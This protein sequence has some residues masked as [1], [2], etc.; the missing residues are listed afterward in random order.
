MKRSFLFGTLALL[1]VNLLGSSAW[2]QALVQEFYVALPET[3]I[4]QHFLQLASGTG[5]TFESVVSITVGNNGTRVVYDH[6]EDGY[7]VDLN[8]PVQSTTQIWGDGNNA[9]GI[10]PGYVNDPVGL[11]AGAVIALRNLVNLPRNASQVLYDGRDRLGASN[12][13]V[14]SRASWATNPGSV[15]ADAVELLSTVDWGTSYVAPVGEDVIFPTPLASS[16]FEKVAMFVQAAENGT[17]VQID[18]NADGVTDTTVTLNRG[19]VHFTLDGVLKGATVTASKPVQV[20]MMVGDINANYE[21]R[22]F[23]LIP[24]AK[25]GIEYYSPVGTASD[26]NQAYAFVYNPHATA[27]EISYRTRVGTGTFSIP[28]KGTYQFLLPQDSATSFLSTSDREFFGVVTAG[29]KPS[30]NQVHDWGFSLAPK[31]NLTTAVVVGWGPGSSDLT[32]NGSPVWVTAMEATRIYV[33][34]NGDRNGPLTDPTGQKYDVYR[35]IAPMEV[36]KLYDPDKDQTA[37][38][39]YT[40]DGALIAAAWGQDPA[41]AGAGNPFLDVGTTVPAFPAPVMIK[42]SRIFTDNGTPGLSVGDVLEYTVRLENKSLVAI[43]AVSLVD[44]LP[45]GL[46]YVPNTTKVGLVPVPDSGVTPFPMDEGGLLVPLIRSKEFTEVT[47]N[48]TVN[49]T[50]TK[51]NVA[52]AVG[53]PGAKASNTINVTGGSGSTVC[54]ILFTGNTGTP[55]VFNPGE[56]IYVTINDADTS[57]PSINVAVINSTNGDT[58]IITLTSISPGVYRNLSPL[59]TS[60]SAGTGFNDGT[61]YVRPGDALTTQH[62]DPQFGDACNANTTIVQPSETKQLYL[63]ADA[64]DNDLTGS[65]DRIDPVATGDTTTNST[66]LLEPGTAAVTAQSTT[67]AVGAT[68]ATSISA[69]HVV[70]AGTNR[71][72]MVGVSFEDDNTSGMTISSVT[73]GTNTLTRA[74]QRSSS[75]EAKG[76]I[77]YMLNPPVGSATVTVTASGVASSDSMAFGATSFVG[78][79][80][81][82][83]FG[84]FAGNTGTGTNASVSVGSAVGDLVYAMLALDDARTATTSQNSLWNVFTETANSDGV[85]SAGSTASGAA[86]NVNMSWTVGSD[87][88]AAMGV[89]IKPASIP[90]TATFAQTPNFVTP[91]S[92][93]AGGAV[94]GTAWVEVPGGYLTNNPTIPATLS[95]NGTN[96]LTLSNPVA[97]LVSGGV[98]TITRGTTSTA[99]ANSTN[100]LTLTHNVANGTNRLLMVSVALGATTTSGNPPSIS[101]VTF[102]GTAMTLVGSRVSGSG[103][104]SDDTISYIYRTIAPQTG[105][106]NVVV[107]LSGNGSVGVTATTF[108]NVDQTTPLGTFVSNAAGSGSTAAVTVSSST[109]E[110]V[111]GTISADEAPTLTAGTG[112]TALWSGSSFGSFTSGGTGVMNGAASVNFSYTKNVTDQDW[113]I[114]AVPIRPN[115]SAAIYRLDWSGALASSQTVPAGQA[116]TLSLLNNVTDTPFRVLYDSETRP[117]R[118]NLPALTVIDTVALDVYDAPYPGGALMPTLISGQTGYVRV[119]VTDPFGTYDITSVDLNIDGPGDAGDISTALDAS[120]VVS[121]NGTVKIYELPWVTTLNTGNYIVSAVSNEG[122]EGTVKSAR[123]TNVSVTQLDLGTP[124]TT[125]FNKEVYDPNE[126]VCVTT[127]DLDENKDPNTAETVTVTVTSGAG[128]SEEIVL[129]E[130]GPDTGIF[131][132]CIPASGTTP[133]DDDDGTLYAPPGT[134]LTV[135]YVD[136][137]DPSDTSGDTASVPSPAASVNVTKT[138]LTPTDG[139]AMVGESVSFRLRVSN[140]GPTTLA[141]VSVTDTFP[142]AN[143]GYQSASITPTAVNSGSLSWS[144]V[145]P[146]APGQT[147]DIIVYFTA[148]AS[149]NPA[150]NSVTVNATGGL[151]SNSSATVVITNPS[152]SVT[153]TLTTPPAGPVGIGDEVVFTIQVQNTGDTAI[154]ELPLEDSFS[155]ALF[156]FVSAT[157]AP[158]GVGSGSLFWAD[159]TG[160]GALAPGQST[161]VSVRLRV[162]GEADPAFNYAEV[163]YATDQYGDPVPPDQ[164]SASIETAAASIRG[165]VYEDLDGNNGFSGPDGRLGGVTVRLYSDP[166]GDGDPADGILVSLTTT[167]S[168]GSYSFLNLPLGNY[169]VVQEDLL[170]YVSVNDTAGSP[171]DNRIPVAVAALTDYTGHDFLDRLLSTSTYGSISGQVRLDADSDGDMSDP[172]SGI[173]GVEIHLYTDPNGDGNPSDGVLLLTTTT[174]GS[175]NY[176]FP[177]VPPGN[178]VVVELDPSGHVSTADSVNPNDN[179]IPVT[180]PESGTVTGNDFLDAAAGGPLATIGDRVWL[181]VN[182]NGLRDGGEPGAEGVV[183]WLYKSTQTPGVDV[184][185]RVTTTMSGGSYEF[186]NLPVGSYTIMLPA[187]NFGPGGALASAPLSSAITNANDDNVDDDDN[188]IQAGAPGTVVVSPLFALGNAEVD[189]TKDF[190]FVPNSS[191]GSISGFVLEDTDNNG[192]GDAPLPGVTVTLKDSSG[193]DIDSDPNTPGV[194][195]TTTVTGPDGGYS[196]ANLPPGSYRIVETHPA[197]YTSVS[198]V[199]GGDLDIIGD[200]TP[201]VVAPGQALTNQTFVEIHFGA[202]SGTVLADTTGNGQGDAPLANVTLTLKDSNGNDIDS[203]PNTPGVQPTTTTTAG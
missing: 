25:W 194:Q 119:A 4:R 136:P 123:T 36:V 161:S 116:I 28:A 192:S 155:G 81:S 199:D 169:V 56:P 164:S 24:R 13:I 131:S 53:Y 133:G 130:T 182:N 44:T 148:L 109:S 46:T 16:M 48:V 102:R 202:I 78:V 54:E 42:T 201:V 174:N 51:T 110:V 186:A 111:F 147:V 170:G 72:L 90:N 95:R 106:G 156:Q 140:T 183:V 21:S 121:D 166:N 71:L 34:Y 128:D 15:L 43:T 92:M 100:S 165:V 22:W 177:L 178:Y 126:T 65:L 120:R 104:S 184:P 2:A 30:A 149:A 27:L 19:E 187:V 180:L 129:T 64:A 172:D 167:A 159:L 39:I 188:G 63:T 171:T 105:N 18:K 38:R 40:L 145:G 181:D 132:A 107:S 118:I 162:V 75:Q 190:G 12:A 87:S 58:E 150:T 203:D 88:W 195:P 84:T 163:L 91:F 185:Y 59:P 37:M 200:V 41:V 114:A 69:T 45:A 115:Q 61:L 153:K 79:N 158:D 197:G 17:Q 137:D 122:F 151:T 127:T 35:D 146:L 76:E 55:K 108:Y 26:G 134:P 73:Y 191:L 86:G 98:D 179:R 117:S 101:G 74:I 5:T 138:R 157:P 50:G 103:G 93:P 83:P 175:G 49:T 52:E 160:A 144:N 143:L 20:H 11:P 125:E 193:N 152:L 135:T 99:T 85:R 176:N 7:E 154:T 67:T 66:A 94:S 96:I 113:A 141:T 89:S 139:Q 3:Q 82:T 47:F 57:L 33:D 70:G 97:T 142:A 198:D 6:W 112:V 9:N 189:S 23:A 62:T 196:F 68:N 14:V 77:W 8:N 60:S 31:N 124:S 173:T 29:A 1:A 80:Q 32:Q 10:P 168:D